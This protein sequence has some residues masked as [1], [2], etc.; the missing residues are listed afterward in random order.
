MNARLLVA[1]ALV[2]CAVAVRG[3]EE[4]SALAGVETV[5]PTFLEADAES[6]PLFQLPKKLKKNTVEPRYYGESAVKPKK[7]VSPEYRDPKPVTRKQRKNAPVLFTSHYFSPLPKKLNGK[8]LR[9]SRQ[10][11][12]RVMVPFRATVETPSGH[13]RHQKGFTEAELHDGRLPNKYDDP[14]QNMKKT[15]APAPQMSLLE[16]QAEVDA[17]TGLEADTTDEAEAQADADAESAPVPPPFQHD[18]GE[19]QATVVESTEAFFDAQHQPP[20]WADEEAVESELLETS[21]TAETAAQRAAQLHMAAFAAAGVELDK[22]KL[23]RLVPVAPHVSADEG[24]EQYNDLEAFLSQAEQQTAS[25]VEVADEV[26]DEVEDES[27]DESDDEADEEAADEDEAEEEEEE[28]EEQDEADDENEEESGEFALVETAA[29]SDESD[30][31]DAEMDEMAQNEAAA[32]QVDMDAT[33]D[34]ASM[35]D[36]QETVEETTTEEEIDSDEQS[37]SAEADSSEEEVST[38]AAI[39]EAADNEEVADAVAL[40]EEDSEADAVDTLLAEVDSHLT[41]EDEA[42]AEAEA[43]AEANAESDAESK[44]TPGHAIAAGQTWEDAQTERLN[45][46]QQQLEAEKAAAPKVAAQVVSS[47]A[48]LQ[49]VDADHQTPQY[50]SV[51]AEVQTVEPELMVET[52]AAAAA[53]AAAPSAQEVL[54][55]KIAQLKAINRS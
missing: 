2:L 25:F 39:E 8:K 12:G 31:V 36:S 1:V 41:G 11:R 21:T 32:A 55:S 46:M 6:S 22:S 51:E 7:Y 54:K 45:A 37:S 30:S 15:K 50:D 43:E 44:G 20:T 3:E 18:E 34:E 47:R 29:A 9:V 48:A 17:Q 23:P 35:A 14:R 40:V 19:Q 33:S 27:E 26:E 53:V 5:E 49:A 52:A 28:E 38:A 4:Q 42:V 16:A 13:R 10:K 24:L